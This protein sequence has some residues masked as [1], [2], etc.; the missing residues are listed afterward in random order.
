M[1]QRII[2]FD[3]DD[4]SHWRAKLKCGH[5]QHVRHAPPLVTREWT[6]TEEG[7]N[8]RIGAELECL[9]CNSAAPRDFVA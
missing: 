3:Q 9:K 5:F 2:G 7:R 1:R 6:L 8:S 4:E